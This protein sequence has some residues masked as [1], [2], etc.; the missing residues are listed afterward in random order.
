MDVAHTAMIQSRT[1]NFSKYLMLSILIVSCAGF[2]FGFD[3]GNIAGALI[4]IK[5]VFHT[6]T[7]QNEWIVSLTLLGAFLSA[8]ASGRAVDKYG[9]KSL[10]IFSAGLFFGGAW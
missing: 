10:L 6:N 3:T 9:R 4:F 5:A 8:I 1:S 7:A 2:L